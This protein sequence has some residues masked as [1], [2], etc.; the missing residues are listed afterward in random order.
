MECN[1]AGHTY[2]NRFLIASLRK[3][4]YSDQESETWKVL[5]E[6]ETGVTDRNGVKH[7]GIVLGLIGDWPFL[8]KSACFT[9]SFNNIPKRVTI[10]NPPVGICHLCRSGQADVD[11]EQ[12]GT[13]R[14]DW[15]QTCFTQDPFVE[16]SPFVEYLLHVPGKE[17]AMWLFDW[18]HT[19]HLGVF[20]NFLGSVL[21]LLSEQ[22]DSANIEGRF[23]ALSESYRT[24]CRNNPKRSYFAKVSKEAIGWDT[25][26]QFPSGGWHK[27]AL[28]TSLMAYVQERFEMES[29]NDE[30]LLVLA[31][32][33]CGAIQ[34]CSKLLYRSSVWLDPGV[35]GMCAEL[36]FKFLRRYAQMATLAK[37]N[38]RNLFVFQPK[39]HVLH[40]FL[41]DMW[42]AHKRNVWGLSPLATSCQPS[43]D[44]I[45]RPSRLARRVTPQ[46]PALDRI[47]DRYL[48]S[49]YHHFVRARYLIRPGGWKNIAYKNQESTTQND[50]RG[51]RASFPTPGSKAKAQSDWRG[52]AQ[53]D[54]Q[55]SAASSRKTPMDGQIQ[56]IGFPTKTP[57][58]QSNPLF[59][60]NFV[61]EGIYI[62]IEYYYLY[63]LIYIYIIYIYLILY[64]Y[65]IL[66]YIYMRMPHVNLQK[67]SL[68]IFTIMPFLRFLRPGYHGSL[69]PSTKP[70]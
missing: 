31:A 33:A 27:G 41:V 12:V 8:H 46:S 18:F 16:P 47:M 34:Q 50:F 60:S 59:L 70:T 42:D 56:N 45:G 36:G 64:K 63:Y 4:D 19:M 58:F 15:I 57:G 25:T 65:I 39:I 49:S 2:A 7:W 29:F 62:Y 43:E 5:M 32:E 3:K 6:W 10:K 14:P 20:R 28:S 23:H 30:P 26:N 51:H 68:G 52:R 9:R 13:R 61:D 53:F 24:W 44:F 1:F 66:I 55:R 40:H 11:F 37:S 38:N 21:A 69:L 67:W 54:E 22:E 17:P 48:Q 35:S